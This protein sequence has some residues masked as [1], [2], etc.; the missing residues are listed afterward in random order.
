M[1]NV[2]SPRF[3]GHIQTALKFDIRLDRIKVLPKRREVGSLGL[4]ATLA[5][6]AGSPG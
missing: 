2:G 4:D 1:R 6:Q 5:C 3:Q